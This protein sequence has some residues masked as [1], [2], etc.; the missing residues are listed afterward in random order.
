MWLENICHYVIPSCLCRECTIDLLLV[1]R[2]GQTGWGGCTFT[3]SLPF[4]WEWL[5]GF[6]NNNNFE[7]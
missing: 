1:A 4:S 6:N 7:I 3:A 2:R 5:V